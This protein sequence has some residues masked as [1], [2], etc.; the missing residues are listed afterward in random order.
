[1]GNHSIGRSAPNEQSLAQ[2]LNEQ[3]LVR[4]GEFTWEVILRLGDLVLPQEVEEAASFP[5]AWQLAPANFLPLGQSVREVYVRVGEPRRYRALWHEGRLFWDALTEAIA[6]LHDERK[7]R[8]THVDELGEHSDPAPPPRAVPI[9]Y[10]A[11]FIIERAF[12]DGK[13]TPSRQEQEARVRFALAL[14]PLCAEAH[15][16]Q[17]QLEE[18]VGDFHRARISYERAMKIAA[19]LIGPQAVASAEARQA[20]EVD[21][22]SDSDASRAYV[23][24]RAA[25]ARLVWGKLGDP[26]GAASLLQGLLV[27]EPNDHLDTRHALLCCLLEADEIETLG[28]TLKQLHFEAYEYEEETIVEDWADTWWLYTHA[29]YLYCVSLLSGQRERA[30]L[31]ATLPLIRA[32]HANSHIPGL[33]LAEKG[34]LEQ[35]DDAE[36]SPGSL[37]EA[38]SYATMALPAWRN[39]PGALKWLG[40][41]LAGL[42]G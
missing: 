14:D 32:F 17:G 20:G 35:G 1:M 37:A 25:L 42:E 29:C 27:L 41:T 24:A 22:W 15:W 6:F 10:M 12:E 16:V 38:F 28:T 19:L 36:S 13:R 23:R 21:F 11:K 26:R 3:E 34:P 2:A 8:I 40:E 33:L 7:N 30:L 39:T 4:L 18:G 5:P 9:D 31:K